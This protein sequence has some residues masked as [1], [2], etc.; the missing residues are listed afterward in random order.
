M[1]DN[2]YAVYEFHSYRPSEFVKASTP[3]SALYPGSYFSLNDFEYKMYNKK[4]LAEIMYQQ[5]IDKKD[6]LILPESAWKI[7]INS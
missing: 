6:R 7:F 4:Y 1:I 2:P 5:V 3:N